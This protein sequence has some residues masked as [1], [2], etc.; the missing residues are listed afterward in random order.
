MLFS[1]IQEAELSLNWPSSINTAESSIYSEPTEPVIDSIRLEFEVQ[2]Y[3]RHVP[4]WLPLKTN[5]SANTWCHDSAA[6]Q[7]FALIELWIKRCES[8]HPECKVMRENSLVNPK[9]LLQISSTLGESRVYLVQVGKFDS[10]RY[11]ALS[12]CWGNTPGFKTTRQNL[13]VYTTEGI[14]ISKLPRT[15]QYAID[16]T[17]RIGCE[18]VW[19]DSICIIQ[20]SNEEWELACETIGYI[21]G[22]VYVVIGATLAPNDSAGIYTDRKN[23][24]AYIE[25]C[26]KRVPILVREKIRH[27]VWQN[28][29]LLWQAWNDQGMLL[30]RCAW[31]FQERLFARRIIHYTQ[32]EIVWECRSDSWCECGRLGTDRKLK[33]RFPQS[34]NFKTRYAQVIKYDCL[35]ALSAI[36][37][38]VNRG[39]LMGFYVAGMWV[40][41]L[42][43]SLLWWSD[44]TS[45]KVAKSDESYK[46]PNPSSALT[47]SWLSVEGSISIWGRNFLSDIKLVNIEYMLAGDNIYGSYNTVKLEL[48]GQMIGVMIYAMAFQLYIARSYQ[49]LEKANFFS[50]TNPFEINPNRLTQRE[51]YALK[52]SRS[53]SVSWNCLILTVSAGGKEFWRVGI[54]EVGLGWFSNASRKRITIV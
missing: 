24:V 3:L 12:Y 14:M 40:D 9:R 43:S 20:D 19:I 27:D 21:Y 31:A 34:N 30:F 11:T 44:A 42:L 37:V 23:E 54:A 16:I 32:E 22:N 29:E 8:D 38:Q 41:W 4:L 25:N 39:N 7:Y 18:Y 33:G 47:W 36:V 46:R 52:Y 10:P 49:S 17:K 6:P 26:G 5:P 51:F 28:D 1:D 53:S 48:E 2:D 35:P 15:Y 45:S 50:D 13:E